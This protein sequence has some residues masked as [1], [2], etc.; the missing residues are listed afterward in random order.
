MQVGIVG[1][2]RSGKTTIFNAVTRGTAQ[3]GAYGGPEG[4]PN[5]GVAKVPDKRLDRLSDIFNPNRKVAAEVSYVDILAAPERLDGT[6]GVAGQYMNLLQRTDALMLVVRVFEDPS[7]SHVD[8]SIDPLRDVETMLLELSFADSE[9]LQ[10]RLAR[11]EDGFKGAK[12]PER[13]GLIREETLLER[14]KTGL[15]D[16]SAIRNQ[17]LTTDEAR[18][19]EG[20]QFLTAKPLIIVANVGEDQMSEVARLEERLSSASEGPRVRTAVLCGKLEMELA[21]MEP[22][23]EQEVRESLSVA[24][25]GLDRMIGLCHDAADLVMFFTGNANEVRAWTVPRGTTAL[26]AA[27]KVHSDFER[28]FIRAEVV[29]FE[30]LNECGS[31]AEARRRGVLRQEGK[32][33]VVGDGDVINVLFNV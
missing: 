12:A 5:I 11:V 3:V 29:K 20:F 17:T 21:Q 27:G 8:E 13:E 10:R 19:L 33:Y 15:E 4:K 22:A 18:R 25:S 30:D 1:L 28:G 14:L 24:D 2:P 23:D 31:L 6:R 32:G 16:G 9:M 26:K 7:V